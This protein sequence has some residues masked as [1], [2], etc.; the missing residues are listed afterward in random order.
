MSEEEYTNISSVSS[1]ILNRRYEYAA[2]LFFQREDLEQ[3]ISDLEENDFPMKQLT[4]VAGKSGNNSGI[5]DV[6]TATSQYY[7]FVISNIPD[8]I[9]NYY[10]HRLDA[11]NYLVVLHGTGILLA[12]AQ[13][14]L[15]RHQIHDFAIFRPYLVSSKTFPNN[16]RAISVST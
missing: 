16:D 12:A 3:A 7:D 11:D 10:N 4:I 8:D 13:Y 15:Q 6:I 2:G 1:N 9:A 5:A 14:I